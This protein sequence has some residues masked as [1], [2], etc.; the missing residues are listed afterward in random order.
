MIPQSALIEREVAICYETLYSV[1]GPADAGQTME[2]V[3]ANIALAI[4]GLQEKEMPN[5]A[6]V[7]KEEITRLARKEVRRQTDALKKASAQH[8]KDG[9]E[10]KR[11]LSELQ[12]KLTALEKQVRKGTPSQVT[13]APTERVRFTAKG[14]RSQRKR[15]G[16]SA[17]DYGKL[18]GVTGQTI[19]S[20]ESE[21]SRP[22]KQQVARLAAIRGI[23]KREVEE[24][25]TRSARK[26]GKKS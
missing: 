11:R 20:W 19:Y 24:R 23:G 22:R 2:S 16:L 4:F 14:L 13:E 26:R 12:R 8:R 7:L 25:L 18:V 6:T 10:M 17:A 1:Q 3:V 21:T 5:I 15:L 9:A